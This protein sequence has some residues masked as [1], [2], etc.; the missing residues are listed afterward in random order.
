MRRLAA[1]LVVF[2]AGCAVGPGAP[3]C[4][5]AQPASLP[6]PLFVPGNNIDCVWETTVDVV[7]NY[8]RI[9][10]EERLRAVGDEFVEGRI[11]TYP[12]GG[13]TIFE[14]WNGDSANLHERVE[15]TLQTIRRYA[16][17][18]V[19]PDPRGQWIDVVVF[20]E[21]EDLAMPEHATSGGATFRY[22]SSLTRVIDPVGGQDISQGWI[23][24]GRDFA[25]EQRMIGQLQERFREQ[26]LAL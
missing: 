22:D 21:L 14:P 2:L 15:S 20:K 3:P 12:T 7:D 8:F 16:V 4:M 9:Q 26:G 5:V 13:A 25:L 1:A 19:I 10:Q 23:P 11:D 24:L 17:V 6:N 18:R